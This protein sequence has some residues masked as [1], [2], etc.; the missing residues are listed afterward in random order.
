VR[1]SGSKWIKKATAAQDNLYT[2][3]TCFYL[4]KLVCV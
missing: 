1:C 2:K 3:K 4:G